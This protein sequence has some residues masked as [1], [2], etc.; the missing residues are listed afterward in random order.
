MKKSLLTILIIFALSIGSIALAQSNHQ[1]FTIP[2][3]AVKVDEDVYSLGKAVVDGVEVEGYIFVHKKDAAAKNGAAQ[4]KASTCYAYF[5][6]GAKWKVVEPWIVNPTNAAGLNSTLVLGKLATDIGT[7][8]IAAGRDI[9]GTG[10]ATSATLSADSTAPDGLN[11][12][13]FAGIDS[14]G[15]IAVTTVWGI[16]SGPAVNRRLVEWDQVYDD[17]DFGWSFSG[18]AGKMDFENIATHELGHAIGMGHP[19]DSCTEETMYRFASSGET[20]KRTLN[21]GDINGI[22]GLYK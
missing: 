3:N 1:K 21:V 22:R 17:I 15:T 14:P 9:L 16:F 20:K 12:V 5:A 11:E 13:Y 18:E 10:N 2:A 6:S 19:S 8:E 7:W 4:N